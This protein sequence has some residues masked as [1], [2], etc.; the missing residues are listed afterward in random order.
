MGVRPDIPVKLFLPLLVS[1]SSYRDLAVM[2]VDLDPDRF[3]VAPGGRD[4]CAP[5]AHKGI[6]HGVTPTNEKSFMQ[7]SGSSTGKGAGW[8]IFVLRS[9][10]NVQSPFV[11]SMNSGT[12]HSI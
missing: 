5:A 1:D 12:T 8:P 10:L 9:P 6:E 3:T 4:E 7:R 2:R 11:Q